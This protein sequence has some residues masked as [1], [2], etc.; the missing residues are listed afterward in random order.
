[1]C[2]VWWCAFDTDFTLYEPLVQ[3]FSPLVPLIFSHCAQQSYVLQQSSFCTG[4]WNSCCGGKDGTCKGGFTCNGEAKCAPCGG[5]HLLTCCML[6]VMI[7]SNDSCAL[8]A[9][10]AVLFLSVAAPIK[11]PCKALIVC[12][13]EHPKM[14]DLLSLCCTPIC[15][16]C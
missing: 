12:I 2:T 16:H 1:M 3:N 13:L 7:L 9:L 8:E 15:T 6:H 4:E 14:S 11:Q 10:H 5:A